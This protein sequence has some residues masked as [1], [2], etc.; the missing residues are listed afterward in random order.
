[1]FLKLPFAASF[2][3]LYIYEYIY[4]AYLILVEVTLS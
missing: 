4:I 1:M 3:V 2:S